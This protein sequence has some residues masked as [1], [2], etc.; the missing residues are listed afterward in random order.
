MK[1]ILAFLSLLIGSRAF[2]Q[3]SLQQYNNQRTGI[4]LTGMRV[5]QSW[6]AVNTVGGA[7]G[8]AS[9]KG[10]DKYFYQMSTF[11]GAVNLGVS[12]LGY[13]NAKK[14]VS[15]PL[16]A[17]ES[18]KAQKK[19]EKI[20]LI[21]AGLDVV[22]TGAGL[23]L[24]THG[25]KKDDEKLQGYGSSVML[26]GIFL[27]VFDGVMYKLQ[28]NSGNGLRKFLDKNSVAFNGKK[29]GITHRF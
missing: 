11:W 23:Y 9:A 7:V 8:W 14:K 5:L 12:T 18:L 27:F 20:F 21:N 1:S 16:S 17:D 2:T 6:G 19:L 22:Y 25:D 4:T 28:R 15:Q 24:K 10:S 29:I 13:L 26:Q 3:D